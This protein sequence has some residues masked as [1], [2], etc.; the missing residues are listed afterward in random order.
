M[1]AGADEFSGADEAVNQRENRAGGVAEVR[2]V[3]EEKENAPK[4]PTNWETFHRRRSRKSFG[5]ANYSIDETKTPARLVFGLRLW[6]TK[7]TKAGK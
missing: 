3:R 4:W 6:P 1:S 2:E 7:Q 5:L